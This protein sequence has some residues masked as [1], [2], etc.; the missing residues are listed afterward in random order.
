VEEELVNPLL[1][2]TER[3]LLLLEILALGRPLI[4]G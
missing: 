2:D 4:G 3:P 1:A